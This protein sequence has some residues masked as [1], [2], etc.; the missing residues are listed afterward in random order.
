MN[1]AHIRR[2]IRLAACGAVL[3][4]FAA[5]VLL[6]TPRPGASQA[7]KAAISLNA[8]TSFPVDI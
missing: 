4:L 2:R 8:P 5:A 7:G 3:L 6:A 1:R